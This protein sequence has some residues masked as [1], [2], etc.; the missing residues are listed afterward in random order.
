[1]TTLTA[2]PDIATASVLLTVTKTA[3]VNRIERTDINGTHEV[4]VPAYTLPSAGTGI[5][6][7]TD[8]EAAD[9]ALTYRV[10]GSGATAAATKTATLAL[11]QPWLFVPALPELSVT[12]PQITSYRSARESSTILHKVIARRDPVVKMG[13]Q[14]L[15]EGQLDIF[16]PD[17]LT[18]RAL[19]AAI[20]S[21][22]ILMLR[23]GVP[24]LDMWFTVSDTDVQPISE[25][26]AQ[27]TYLYSMR[28]QETARP[29]DKLKG[30]RGWT[31]AELATSFATYADVTAAYATYGDLLINKEA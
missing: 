16:C 18:T 20:D 28:F 9:G 7:V 13:K 19:D 10:Y 5:L 29:V 12:V 21:G 22:E 23:Q 14:G 15:R 27:T 24:G 8:Y 17:Y 1:M 3:T 26:G 25:E 2:T 30:A 6:H 31:Y 11:A 4:R